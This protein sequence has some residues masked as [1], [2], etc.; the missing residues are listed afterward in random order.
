MQQLCGEGVGG[1]E[2]QEMAAVARE[3]IM[4]LAPEVGALIGDQGQVARRIDAPLPG[5]VQPAAV[6]AAQ[7]RPARACAA[8]TPPMP[9]TVSAIAPL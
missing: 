6:A 2:A 9:G 7:H 8:A 4:R 5:L 1:G 3:A